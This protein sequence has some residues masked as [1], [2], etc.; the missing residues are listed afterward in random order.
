VRFK[1]NKRLL[2]RGRSRG[3]SG[4]RILY[5]KIKVRDIYIL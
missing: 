2:K 3:K 1:S 4:S 5:R